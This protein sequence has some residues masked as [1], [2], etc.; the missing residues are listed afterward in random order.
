MRIISIRRTA[1]CF[2][3]LCCVGQ[4]A[5]AQT[6]PVGDDTDV[7]EEIIV[8]GSRIPR[9]AFESLQPATVLDAEQLELRGS[10]SLAAM[11]NEQAG[12]ST[13]F[14]SPIGPQNGAEVGQNFVDFLGLGPRRTLTLVN[15]RRFPAGVSPAGRGGLSVDLN[16]I[17]E[18]LV[19]RVETIAVGG[20]PI[21][22]SDA[23]AGTVN[24]ILKDD[25]EGFDFVGSLG[26]SPDFNDA[27][28]YR[29]GATWGTNFADG[30]GNIA[31]ATQFT[32]VNGIRYTDRRE[33]ASLVGFETPGDPDSPYA[34]ELFQDLTVAVDNNT[35]YPLFFGDMFFFNIAGNGIPLDIND[36]NSP[37]SQFDQNGN[38]LPF[39]PGGGTGSPIFQDGGDGLKLSEFRSLYTDL[40]RLNFNIL[41]HYDLTDSTRLTAELWFA[42]DDAQELVAQPYYQSPIFGGLPANNYG[43]VG[44]GPLPVL[45]DNPYL[46]PATRA[47][48]GAALDVVHDF[49]NDG[50]ADPTIDTDGDGVPDAVGFWRG[51]PLSNILPSQDSGATRYLY[52]AA[53]GLDGEIR[54]ADRDFVW[55]AW[56]SYGRTQSED[57]Y[58]V[59]IKPRLDQAIQVVTGSGGEP[60]CADPSNGCVPL[61]VIGVPSAE[62][63]DYVLK[64]VT[65]DVRIEQRVISANIGGDL[66]DLP[67]GPVSASLGFEFRNEKA[68]FDPNEFS[69]NGM[70]SFELVPIS[71]QFDSREVY[72][73]TLVP[74]LGSSRQ[75][76]L[77]NSLEFE[78]AVRYVDNSIAGEDTTWT[79]GLR[80]RP[81]EDIE[82]RGNLTESI[83]AP[84]IT[85]LFTPTSQIVVF[86]RDP[87]D[88]RFIDQGNVPET[89]AANCAADGITQPFTSFIVNASQP[90]T[91][92]GNPNLVSEVAESSTF[93]IIFRPRFID[94]FTLSVDWFDI[95]IT[96]A[97]E[98]LGPTDIMTACYDSSSFRSEP[99]CDLFDRDPAGQVIDLQT[100]FVNVGLI[101]FEGIQTVL[102]YDTGLGGFGDLTVRLNHQFTEKLVETPGSGNANYYEGEVGRSENR[103]NLNATWRKGNWKVF[104]QFR[105]LSS[106]VFDNADDEFTRNP[107]GID[108][109]LVIDSGVA[110]QLS[111]GIELQLNVDNLLDEDPPYAAVASGNGIRAY[112]SGVRGRYMT[113]TMRATF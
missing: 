31:L 76:G 88:S 75:S 50:S 62:A 49:D 7:A 3:V 26:G 63:I 105:W 104:S 81:I 78:G 17:P 52:R 16:T 37:I 34:L 67:A 94:G 33:T 103:V 68:A 77:M 97:I 42:R 89:R 73:E 46:L 69:E 30:R 60:A 35:A 10:T 36:P 93:G 102:S 18:V 4:L 55:D 100:G 91:L 65:D 107:S 64:S 112:Y 14:T 90:A 29:L 41:G 28:E 86:A 98:N 9:T 61:D 32:S 51:G 110:Y 2:T 43:N 66:F 13:P 84:S 1:A 82:L 47:T 85:E 108:D 57:R 8:T 106:A 83:R 92:S 58:D 79:A 72:F 54:I 95:E 87:C 23:I 39:V 99:A 80:Y 40:E 44:E 71:G 74:L 22:G 20:A 59:I 53:V 48:I 113:L 12:F 27:E 21:Y 38:L 5:F 56:I 101:E 11:L 45:I 96:N 6:A 111:D 109:W 19:D 70:T 25:F 15:G 24:I